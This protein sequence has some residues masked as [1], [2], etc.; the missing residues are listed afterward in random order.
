MYGC[1]LKLAGYN[2]PKNLFILFESRSGN[3]LM[4]RGFTQYLQTNG[5]VYLRP[6]QATVQKPCLIAL[7]I[8]TAVDT[9]TLS[10]PQTNQTVSSLHVVGS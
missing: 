5:E 3:E 8:T 2:S 1:L 4:F 7:S 9:H 6:L 10:N